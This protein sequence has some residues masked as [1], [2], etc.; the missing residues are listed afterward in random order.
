MR[1][2]T[3]EKK[4]PKICKGPE[5]IEKTR[6][7]VAVRPGAQREAAAGGPGATLPPVQ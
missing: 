5:R 3:A 4:F 1:R 2:G 6:L 7:P